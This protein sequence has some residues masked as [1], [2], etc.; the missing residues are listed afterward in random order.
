MVTAMVVA[1]KGITV[2]VAAAKTTAA[3]A[4]AGGKDTNQLKA[5]GEETMAAAM[6][7]ATATDMVMVTA[8]KMMLMPTIGHQQQQ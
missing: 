2:A 8:K 1:L 5:A 7:T 4:M 3:T 6:E